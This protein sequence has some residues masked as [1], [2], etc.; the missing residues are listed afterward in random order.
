LP[1]ASAIEIF[2]AAHGR[3]E[4]YAAVRAFVPFTIGGE[5][6][7]LAG[8]TCTPLVKYPLADLQPGA[9]VKG[10]SVIELGNGNTPR[11]MFVYEKNGKQY[12]LMNTFRMERMHKANPV[13]PSQYWAAKVDAGI[14]TETEKVNEK[15][16]RRVGRNV[17]RHVCVGQ[18]VRAAHVVHARPG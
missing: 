15:A 13:G 16:I 14:L 9:K 8:F 4:D 3:D 17:E 6:H 7:L 18:V 10:T 12:I 1:A 11:D 5:P 2:H